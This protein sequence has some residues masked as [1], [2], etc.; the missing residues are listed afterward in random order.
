MKSLLIAFAPLLM[1][2]SVV[3]T[4]EP[5]TSRPAAVSV[6]GLDVTTPAGA[7]ELLQRARTAAERACG[8]DAKWDRWSGDYDRCRADT[9]AALVAKADAPVLTAL[10]RG[11]S[12]PVQV[13]AAK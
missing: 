1:T 3:A 12:L 2:A 11:E 9:V 4:A 10:H 13:A 7:A 5:L 6:A 8:L